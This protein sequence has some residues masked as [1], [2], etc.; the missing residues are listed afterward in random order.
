MLRYA[1]PLLAERAFIA[2]QALAV[3]VR[4]SAGGA[5]LRQTAAVAVGVPADSEAIVWDAWRR[6]DGKWVVSATYSERNKARTAEWTYDHSGRNI[7][8]LDDNARTLMGVRS[9]VDD[10]DAIADALDLVA[11]PATVS[12]PVESRPR[13]VAVPDADD[14]AAADESEDSSK[15]APIPHPSIAEEPAATLAKAKAAKPKARKG[16]AHVPSW[17]EILFGAT[18][19]D[20]QP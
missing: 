16:R 3:E 17:D 12:D 9:I 8:P 20:D 1:E 19:P 6:E 18:R 2:E 4:R 13:L 15:T 5:T 11:E 7:H 14:D 10:R